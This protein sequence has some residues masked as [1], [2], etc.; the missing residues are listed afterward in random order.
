VIA[1]ILE[2]VALELDALEL[3]ALELDGGLE[4]KLGNCC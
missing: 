1:P 2:L 4:S 3:D